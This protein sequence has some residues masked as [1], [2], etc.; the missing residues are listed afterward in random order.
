VE[1]AND[2][3][4]VSLTLVYTLSSNHT[5][6]CDQALASGGQSDH[7]DAYFGVFSLYTNAISSPARAYKISLRN[8]GHSAVRDVDGEIHSHVDGS[9]CVYAG[10]RDVHDEA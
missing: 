7:D 2:C 6:L 8:M 10:C 3:M 4:D 5:F 1:V 9:T